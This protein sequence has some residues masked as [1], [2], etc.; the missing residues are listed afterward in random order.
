MTISIGTTGSG[1]SGMLQGDES[2]SVTISFEQLQNIIRDL[3]YIEEMK[4]M[5][6]E[7]SD[8][9]SRGDFTPQSLE[10]TSVIPV[11]GLILARVHVLECEMHSVL[12]LWKKR[13]KRKIAS[14]RSASPVSSETMGWKGDV[15]FP[16]I[17]FVISP[18]C[19]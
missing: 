11:S 17:H 3:D 6:K 15:I 8:R 2:N 19:I 10:M 18:F 4:K 1:P 7:I 9:Q 12:E 16:C 5:D 14:A 13:E